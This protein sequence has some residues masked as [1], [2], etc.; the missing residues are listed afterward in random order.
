M[1][2]KREMVKLLIKES[3]DVK[4]ADKIIEE[5]Y[6]FRK[7]SDK[8]DFLKGMFDVTVIGDKSENSDENNYWT[9]LETILRLN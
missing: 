7:V 1:Q 8:S 9:L 3:T 5:N 4:E 2:S 6:S